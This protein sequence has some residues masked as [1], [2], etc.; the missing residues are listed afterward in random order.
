MTA[1]SELARPADG[2]FDLAAGATGD[3]SSFTRNQ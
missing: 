2:L 1:V 3:D